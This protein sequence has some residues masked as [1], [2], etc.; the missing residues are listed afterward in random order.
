VQVSA[1]LGT[2]SLGPKDYA[3]A[4]EHVVALILRGC[5]L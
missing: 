1:V 3:R 5:G 4:T 2:E